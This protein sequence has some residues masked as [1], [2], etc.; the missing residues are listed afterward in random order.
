[1]KVGLAIYP[2]RGIHFPSWTAE[3]GTLRFEHLPPLFL[4][5]EIS[6]ETYF[7]L[8]CSFPRERLKAVEDLLLNSSTRTDR[9]AGLRR[10]GLQC[11]IFSFVLGLYC[12]S[13]RATGVS[14][15]QTNF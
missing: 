15:Q 11:R 14:P 5:P 12:P 2:F 4:M 8:F 3:A 1:M 10:K 9:N 13:V 7:S 6:G